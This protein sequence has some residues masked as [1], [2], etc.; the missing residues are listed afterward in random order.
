MEISRIGII[1]H[2]EVEKELLL[3]TVKK[4]KKK[5]CLLYYDPL[6]AKKIGEKPTKTS[7]MNV[8]LAII[9]GGDGTLLWSVNELPNRPMILG[10][11]TGRVGYLTE[12]SGDK[13]EE[14]VDK[15]FRKEFYI[16][17]RE[18]LLVN[19]K[20]DVLNELVLLPQRPA[21][22]LD[23]RISLNG[24]KATEFRA[25]GVIVATQTGSTG[26]SFSSGGPI[27]HPDAKAYLITPM[28]AFMREQHPLV[29]PDNMST[30]IEFLGKK[31]DLYLILDGSIVK[32]IAH[33]GRV[34]VRKSENT[35][36]FIRFTKKK[37]KPKTGETRS[38]NR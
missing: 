16:D 3:R 37:W 9:F 31:K 19:E 6:T 25:D 8:D 26:H 10:V 18:K 30:E 5:D 23:F 21:S 11:N 2:P 36:K 38:L 20:Y 28:I 35:A 7:K 32:K 15:I 24:E 22:L 27:I 14:Y 13:A 29:V 33:S 4:L 12:I 17:E 1:S 34:S